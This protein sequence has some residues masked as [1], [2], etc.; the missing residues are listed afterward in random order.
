MKTDYQIGNYKVK[1]NDYLKKINYNN[2]QKNP[3]PFRQK[4]TPQKK[5]TKPPNPQNLLSSI[6]ALE[7]HI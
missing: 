7:V 3:K 1:L 5:S 6:R 2:K 4:K